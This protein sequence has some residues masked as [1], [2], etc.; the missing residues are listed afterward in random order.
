[1]KSMIQIGG[2]RGKEGRMGGGRKERER[3]RGLAY[4]G[5]NNYLPF[6]H[7]GGTFSPFKTWEGEPPLEVCEL[8]STKRMHIYAYMCAHVRASFVSMLMCVFYT[9]G[10][11]SSSRRALL[12]PH[13]TKVGFSLY[14]Y[15]TTKI[16]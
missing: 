6:L 9:L 13:E 3:K 14:G 12:R 1:M 11:A 8:L 15:S 10:H 16:R 5:Q 2:K 4:P 7:A